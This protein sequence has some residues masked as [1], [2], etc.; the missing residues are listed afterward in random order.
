[1]IRGTT[2]THTFTLPFNTDILSDIRV[3]YAQDDEVLFVK[4]KEDCILRDDCILINLTQEDTF[5]FDSN[6]KVQI[7]VRVL[8]AKGEVL[9]SVIENIGVSQCLEDEVLQ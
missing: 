2:P 9:S 1:M 4:R 3:I 7:Q 8:T 5:M 6:K